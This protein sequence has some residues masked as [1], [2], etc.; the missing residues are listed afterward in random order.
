M[1]IDTHAHLFYPDFTED[2]VTVIDNAKKAS[3]EAIIVPATDLASTAKAVALS[4][5]HNFIFATAGIHPH[6]TAEWKPDYADLLEQVIEENH[7]VMAVGEIGLDYYYDYSP[8][9]K[10]IEA[11]TAQLDLALKHKLPAV[12]HNRDA[13]DDVMDIVVPYCEKGLKAQFHCFAGTYEDALKLQEL[14]QYIS[15]TGNITF[16]K[17]EDVRTVAR[18]VKPEFLLLETDS[19]FMTPEPYRGKR[20]EPSYVRIV[21]EKMAEL[22]DIDVN[23]LASITTG[24]AK[25]LFGLNGKKA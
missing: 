6:D 21:A 13:N 23:E 4:K 15:F 5:E 19:P 9:E 20:N 7:K 8:R 11:F 24:N 14:E 17:R 25:R 1:F 10:Q 22:L 2:I 18:A 16:K 12:I 3:V